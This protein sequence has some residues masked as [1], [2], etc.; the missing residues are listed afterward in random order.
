MM[1]TAP[2]V[3]VRELN[4]MIESKRLE[5]NAAFI[6]IYDTCQQLV[7]RHAKQERLRTVFEVPEFILGI[8]PFNLNDAITYV[9]DRLKKNGFMVSYF[10]PKLLYISWDVDEISGKKIVQPIA[11]SPAG[12]VPL[13]MPGQ[14]ASQSP[15]SLPQQASQAPQLRQLPPAIETRPPRPAHLAM[16]MPSMDLPMPMAS[17]VRNRQPQSQSQSQSH[18]QSHPQKLPETGFFKSITDYKP[19]GKFVLDLN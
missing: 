13:I 1:S 12:Q 11:M 2:S 7:I 8:P 10:F 4:R 5:R 9:I 15:Q 16:T 17:A 19:S 3:N 14:Q 18:P 6:Q